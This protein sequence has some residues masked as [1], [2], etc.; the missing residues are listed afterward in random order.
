MVR[1]ISIK[2]LK[3]KMKEQR[4]LSVKSKNRGGV[5]TELLYRGRERKRD[6]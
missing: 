5:K 3:A 2:C 4:N 1:T 6:A